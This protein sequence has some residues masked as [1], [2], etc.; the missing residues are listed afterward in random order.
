MPLEIPIGLFV[1]Y[2]DSLKLSWITHAKTQRCK[3]MDF[4]EKVIERRETGICAFARDLSFM[5]A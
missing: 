4:K 3:E 1:G 5:A 2:N